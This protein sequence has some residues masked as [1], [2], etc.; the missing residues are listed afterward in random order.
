MAIK[1]FLFN[2]IPQTEM[3]RF[4]RAYPLWSSTASYSILPADPRPVSRYLDLVDCG[5][6]PRSLIR[7]WS[8]FEEA[9]NVP[10]TSTDKMRMLIAM[11]DAN[12]SLEIATTSQARCFRQQ[13][14]TLASSMWKKWGLFD[15]HY[16]DLKNPDT[17]ESLE[18]SKKQNAIGFW[19]IPLE[20]F[21]PVP[22]VPYDTHRWQMTRVCDFTPFESQIQLGVFHIT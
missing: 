4:N 13:E 5:W 16:P 20:A 6:D 1:H 19:S 3:V 7:A 22:E 9:Y 12:E 11:T 14:E 17:E 18:F 10:P 8:M 15:L 2:E 21:G